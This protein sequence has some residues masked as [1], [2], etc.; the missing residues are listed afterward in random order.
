[1]SQRAIL[2]CY[3]ILAV[4][5]VCKLEKRRQDCGKDVYLFTAKL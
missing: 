1:M 2:L 5:H 4:E 3:S